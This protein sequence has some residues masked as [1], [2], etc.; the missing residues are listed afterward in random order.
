MTEHCTDFND[1]VIGSC[2]AS[3]MENPR[4]AHGWAG[5]IESFLSTPTSVVEDALLVHITGLYGHGASGLQMEAWSEEIEL[6]R[7]SFRNLAISR[8]DSLKWSIIFEYELPLEGGRRPDVLLLSPG[9]LSVLEFKQDVT[10][11]R[12]AVEQVA[13]YARDLSEYHSTTHELEVKPYIV[14]TRSLNTRVASENVIALSPELIA[15]EMDSLPDGQAPDLEAWLSGSYS[16]LPTLIAAAKMIFNNERLPAIKRAESNGVWRAVAKL[17]EISSYAK[18]NMLPAI[19]FVAGVPGAGKTLVG[20]QF[21]HEESQENINS[22]FLS[23]NGPLVDVLSGALKSSVFVKDLH[24]FIKTHGMTL[25]VPKQHVIVFD[26]A[27]RAWDAT[28]MLN[29]NGVAFSEPEL[30]IA[31]G[32]RIP[33]WA[34]LVGLIGHGQEINSGEEAGISGWADAL[35]S[36]EKGET[37]RVF[38]PP[39]FSA[40]FEGLNFESVPELDLTKSLRSKKAEDLHSWVDNLLEGRFSD[41][42]S[43]ALKMQHDDFNIFIT[44]DLDLAKSYLEERYDGSEDSRYGILASAKDKSLPKFGIE[45]GFFENK[46]IKYRDWYN[47]P[48]GTPGSCCNFEAPMTEFGSQGLELDMALMA[49]GDDFLWDGKVWAMRRMRTKYPQKDPH[50]LRKN[51]YRVLLTRSRDGLVIFVPELEK[52]DL[53]EFSLLASGAKPLTAVIDFSK[54]A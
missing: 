32:E 40:S 53:T 51:S 16:P 12:A 7:L 14:P 17:Q 21:V 13:A 54:I 36:S 52:F 39:R 2:L 23:G 41:A 22:V 46:R 37:W 47:N 42:A 35:L 4:Q 8:P 43:I 31:I 18:Q 38:T 3:T 26:E 24:S 29:K 33:E 49:W 5:S 10:I 27:Q 6:I 44:R 30:L 50:T 19:A 11:T 20:L 9:V 48:K 34:T 28:H 15:S 45:N 25:K 1:Y